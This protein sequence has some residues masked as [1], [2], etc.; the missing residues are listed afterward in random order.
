MRVIALCGSGGQAAAELES[1]GVVYVSLGM[2]KGLADPRGWW[3]FHLWLRRNRPDIVHAHL[4]HAIW[5]ARWSRLA[6]PIP[7][8]VDTIH[9]SATGAL[10][11]RLGFRLSDW[12]S[13]SVTAVSEAAGRF[14]LNARMASPR[15]LVVLPNCVDVEKWRP[16]AAGRAAVRRELGV[17]DEFVWLAAGRLDPVNLRPP[18]VKGGGWAP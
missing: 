7:L 8:L 11:R 18:I 15:K 3:R 1:L 16:D 6:A 17:T 4:P 5:L 14:A 13:D 9:T 12:L 2:R 10:G